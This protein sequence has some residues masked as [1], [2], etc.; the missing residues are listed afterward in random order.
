LQ[1]DLLFTE[2]EWNHAVLSVAAEMKSFLS[3]YRT[4]VFKDHGD[5]GE[6]WGSGS[7]LALNGRRFL[8]TNEHVST[9]RR[10]GQHL[11]HQFLGEEEIYRIVGDHIEYRWPLDLAVL[12]VS[13]NAWTRK[14]HLSKTIQPDQIAFA[15]D[16][17]PGELLTFT[18]FA[19]ERT[20]FYFGGLASEGTC[21]TAREAGLPHDDRFNSRFHFGIDYKPDVAQQFDG[22]KGL[23]AP[24]GLS[25]STVWDTRF[26]AAKM[27]GENWSPEMTKVTGVIWGW[28]SAAGILV[29]TRA[30]YV[31]SFLLA[32]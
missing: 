17:V 2:D 3:A 6:G 1:T 26:V 28:P 7:Y 25:R 19:G 22:K 30:E 32:V 29:A 4:P 27:A 13:E 5:Y 24:P 31:R 9:V 8:L 15:H 14:P 12:P 21:Y 18:G 20:N 23:P 16:P 11:G 10:E